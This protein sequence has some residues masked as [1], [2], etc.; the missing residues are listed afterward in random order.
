MKKMEARNRDRIR[1]PR[2]EILLE[3]NFDDDGVMTRAYNNNKVNQRRSVYRSDYSIDRFSE[4]SL[5][6]NNH[7][8]GTKK[9]YLKFFVISS[10][11]LCLFCSVRVYLI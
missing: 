11:L 9:S 8:S 10:I 7:K 1:D 6:G 4:A 5:H 3:T 2:E